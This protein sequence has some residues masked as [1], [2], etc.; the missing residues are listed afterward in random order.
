ML[1]CV[2]TPA[3][4]ALVLR[5]WARIQLPAALSNV[6]E[7]EPLTLACEKKDAGP[8]AVPKNSAL[9]ALAE[10]PCLLQACRQIADDLV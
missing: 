4:L 5:N 6:C 1:I 3:S 8:S 10:E 9:V 7:F 2:H